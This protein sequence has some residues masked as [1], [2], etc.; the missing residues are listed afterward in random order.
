MTGWLILF[1]IAL[2]IIVSVVLRR[3]YIIGKSSKHVPEHDGDSW[4]DPHI[5]V[6]ALEK[7]SLHSVGRILSFILYI[8]VTVFEEILH[9]AMHGLRSIAAFLVK[10]IDSYER[11]HHTND[12]KSSRTGDMK[13]RMEQYSQNK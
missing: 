2:A 5:K 6:E 8:I 12:T 11:K 7:I 13:D 10:R 4:I 1:Y 3:A 9:R